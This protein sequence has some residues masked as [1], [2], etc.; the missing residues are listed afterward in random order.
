MNSK[1]WSEKIAIK[2]AKKQGLILQKIHWKIIYFYR[3]FYNKN[4]LLPN[5]KILLQYLNNKKHIYNSFLLFNL[6]PKG[7]N[8]QVSDIC[9][10]SNKIFI[11]F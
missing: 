3:N 8:K 9:C 10:L 1:N 5:S 11:C 7:L 4:G 6:F 2:I